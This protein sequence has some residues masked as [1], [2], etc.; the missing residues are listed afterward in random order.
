MTRS[1]RSAMDAT[2]ASRTFQTDAAS[3]AR[4]SP[5]RVTPPVR[6]FL[7]ASEIAMA[8]ANLFDRLSAQCPDLD[9][10]STA[11]LLLAGLFVVLHRLGSEGIIRIGWVDGKRT[12]VTSHAGNPDGLFVGLDLSDD[13]DFD[14]LQVRIAEVIHHA[15]SKSGSGLTA[16]GEQPL[17]TIDLDP[18]CTSCL[19]SFE[20]SLA[21]SAPADP[22]ADIP[23]GL[24]E[25]VAHS[26][27]YV[28][29]LV[30]AD[31]VVLAV[32]YD[33]ER[34]SPGRMQRLLGHM[35]TVL[36]AALAKPLTRLSALPI[37]TE[38]Q[39]QQI[40][41]DWNTTTVPY[42]ASATIQ[43]IFSLQARRTPDAIALQYEAS[44]L[45]Y[46][47]LEQQSDALAKTL[48]LRGVPAGSRI[49][50]LV[51]RCFDLVIAML[52][53][54]KAGGAYVPLD[55]AYPISRLQFM[56]KDA[57][58]TLIL[59]Q[60]QFTA[61]LHLS[62]ESRLTTWS[63]EE[64]TLP[65]L[66]LLAIDQP[67]TTT[68]AGLTNDLAVAETGTVTPA[69]VLYTSGSS[70]Q[71]KGV[72]TSHRG[73]LRLVCGNDYVR[74][75][76]NRVFCLHSPATFDASTF[77]IWGAL[78]H[79]ATCIVLPADQPTPRVLGE[80]LRR[81]HVTTLFMT[82]ALFNTVVDEEP[83]ALS[84]AEDILVGGEALSVKH[85]RRARELLPDARL[86]N[87]Y[88]PTETTT[89]A[90]FYEIPKHVPRDLLSIPIG[91]P[92]SNTTAYV[93]DSLLQPAPI[94]VVGELF[95]GGDGLAIAYLE[96]PELTAQR[97]VPD[98]F[99]VSTGAR[100]YRTGDL[101]RRLEDG[102]IEFVGRVDDQ[103]KIRGFRIEPGEI[104]HALRNHTDVRDVTIMV[105]VD[106][107]GEKRLV[108]YVVTGQPNRRSVNEWR[109]FLAAVLPDFMVPSAW[110]FLDSLPM[111]SHGKVDRLQL[112]APV[113]RP[114]G[115][116]EPGNIPQS[117]LEVTIGEIWMDVLN[118]GPFG[119][120]DDFFEAGGHSLSATRVASRIQRL[121]R[122]D[123][124]IRELFEH[125]TIAT[126]AAHITNRLDQRK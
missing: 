19:F 18:A 79:G 83:D 111:T 13:P 21:G 5:E 76:A 42:P 94:G 15:T 41:G 28:K 22:F 69:Y 126:I 16:I 53:I 56:I 50:M 85:V 26:D 59:A 117:A 106:Q 104:E 116:D 125:R 96:R 39:R 6:S 30:G 29:V 73:V 31:G 49:G 98:P 9:P 112:P 43:A 51:E 3:V 122:I 25:T 7:R 23:W 36:V 115:V 1:P 92:I 55:P 46:G 54:L 80:R 75:G 100:L 27:L 63:P 68:E 87:V 33:A 40:L 32:D 108:A 12:T 121:L 58:L 47:A 119:I 109:E 52:G 48:M 103:V 86:V 72:V 64:S 61:R 120:D 45:T 2:A 8:D 38:A 97:F 110:V 11:R 114:V 10:D 44:S 70:G 65:A 57:G 67:S 101:A 35:Q 107:R 88:G 81:H 82:T 84:G 90:T 123:I 71:P 118:M 113:D 4:L 20:R 37:L 105:Q 93:L 102:C 14:T 89:F 124:G 60:P 34:Y 62:G 91:R 95:I 24:S 66:Q 77:E 74:F 78:L 17:D 99:I